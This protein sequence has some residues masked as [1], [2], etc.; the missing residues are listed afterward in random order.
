[1][2]RVATPVTPEL[3]EAVSEFRAAIRLDEPNLDE[4]S[5]EFQAALVMG[6]AMHA[7]FHN[8]TLLSR[9]TGVPYSKVMRF[10]KNLRRG[11]IWRQDGKIEMESDLDGNTD[12]PA[13]ELWLHVLVAIGTLRRF[14]PREGGTL[15]LPPASEPED[16][17]GP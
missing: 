1:M 4:A 14:P 11:G 16:T 2:G 9:A 6:A 17:S 13:M 3:A 15:A 7:G 12:E 10:A 8:L 5:L